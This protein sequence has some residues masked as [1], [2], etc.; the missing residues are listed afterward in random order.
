MRKFKEE[1]VQT[2]EKNKEKIDESDI[3][4]NFLL[5]KKNKE[6][7]KQMKIKILK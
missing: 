6:Q 5:N 1:K 3:G 2:T 4:K 7:V